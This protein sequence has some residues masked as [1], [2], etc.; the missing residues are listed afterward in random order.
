M[1]KLHLVKPTVDP[2]ADLSAE[3]LLLYKM[4]ES[5]AER[6]ADAE[7]DILHMMADIAD[8]SEE[9]I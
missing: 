1:T 4:I 2:L 9:S 6:I 8:H 7:V 5:L 3:S